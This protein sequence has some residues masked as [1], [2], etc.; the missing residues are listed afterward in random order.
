[1]ND[2]SKP[3]RQ[4]KLIMIGPFRYNNWMI[5]EDEHMADDL[6]SGKQRR[7]EF[8]LESFD[9]LRCSSN[10]PGSA[11]TIRVGEATVPCSRF[12]DGFQH[13]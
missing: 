7:T 3:V 2:Q 5:Q 11:G 10:G 6:D 8:I 4:V 13:A 1:M 12:H 9:T